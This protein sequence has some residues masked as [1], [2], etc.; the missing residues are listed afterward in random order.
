MNPSPVKVPIH[1][2]PNQTLRI[3]CGLH[4]HDEPALLITPHLS[5]AS[6]APLASH[7]RWQCV[8]ART[9]C[10]TGTP[11]T[12]C[13]WSH[14]WLCQPPSSNHISCHPAAPLYKQAN[15]TRYVRLC[16]ARLH[17][18]ADQH[19]ACAAPECDADLYDFAASH[20][21]LTTKSCCC[22]LGKCNCCGCAGVCRAHKCILARHMTW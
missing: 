15:C 2:T 5:T 22:S 10:A 17:S 11:C 13:V 12:M 8:P 20:P 1:P 9:L 16:T 21:N 18:C 14:P 3:V 4:R 19:A 6:P 7:L